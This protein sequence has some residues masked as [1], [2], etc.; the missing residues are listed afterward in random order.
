MLSPARLRRFAAAAALAMVAAIGIV[1]ATGS[2]G[3]AAA[4]RS[5]AAPA[6]A[7]ERLDV[8]ALPRASLSALR[9]DPVQRTTSGPLPFLALLTTA[10]LLAARFLG[11][12]APQ[13]I[14][15]AAHPARRAGGRHDRGPPRQ[16]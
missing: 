12:P 13:L 3:T 15:L 1:A 11:R 5:S 4:A 2:P 9:S 6:S 14:P 7:I 8:A 16:Q 10:G